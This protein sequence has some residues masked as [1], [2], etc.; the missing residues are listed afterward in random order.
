MPINKIIIGFL[1]LLFSFQLVPDQQ[2][3]FGLYS[4][5]ITEEISDCQETENIK[6]GGEVSRH[7]E[8]T[9]L[10][11]FHKELQ[12]FFI[13]SGKAFAVKLLTRSSDDIQTPPPNNSI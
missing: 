12:P 5:L 8:S 6:Y 3:G 11:S 10:V 4:N 9:H 13:I 1:L 2:V 7:F